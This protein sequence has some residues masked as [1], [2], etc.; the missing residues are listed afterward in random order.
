MLTA[1]KN[2]QIY[3]DSAV[4]DST[5]PS[6]RD[7][8]YYD[9]SISMLERTAYRVYPIIQECASKL[10]SYSDPNSSLHAKIEDFQSIISN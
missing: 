9:D 1:K 8:I 6:I 4:C 2:E 7:L 10:I 5:D 3:Q